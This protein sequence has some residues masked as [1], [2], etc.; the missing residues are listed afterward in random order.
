MLTRIVRLEFKTDQT[1][2][3]EKIFSES[4]VLIRN[5]EGCE[6]LSLHKDFENPALYYTVSKWTSEDALNQYR[7][8]SLFKTTWSKTK[9]LF[10]GKPRAFSLNQLEELL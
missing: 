10:D 5:F 6:Y 9:V 4:K 2:K 3:F 1:E 8:S 7:D